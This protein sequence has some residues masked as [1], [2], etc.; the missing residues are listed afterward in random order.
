MQCFPYFFPYPLTNIKY[1]DRFTETPRVRNAA[2]G[3]VLFA[4]GILPEFQGADT[5]GFVKDLGEI[6]QGGETE[7][8][9]DLGHRQV[10]FR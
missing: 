7:Y 5:L 1:I 4:V 8:V 9:S 6:T 2:P 3:I 10:R